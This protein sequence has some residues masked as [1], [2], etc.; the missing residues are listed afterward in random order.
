MKDSTLLKISLIFGAI[1]LIG[2][3][4]ITSTASLDEISISKIDQT[5]LDQ[6][7]KITGKIEKITST[8]KATF[9][10]ISKKE[11]IT[12]VVFE[13]VDLEKGSFVEVIGQVDKYKG[14]KEL[15]VEKIVKK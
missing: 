4:I 8:E 14:E 11:T 13:P 2:L 3:S 12:A 9:L 5:D 7:V 10:E 6:K 15:L 1:G